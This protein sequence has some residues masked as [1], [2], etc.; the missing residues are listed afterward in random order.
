VACRID[1]DAVSLGRVHPGVLSWFETPIGE[2]DLNRPG[3]SRLNDLI[4]TGYADG[5]GYKRAARQPVMAA[6][7][8]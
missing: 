2:R 5:S 1:L 4:L 3:M 6:A 8:A 7:C